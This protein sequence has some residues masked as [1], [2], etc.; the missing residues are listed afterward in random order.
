MR[1]HAVRL[2]FSD[3][4]SYAG[5]DTTVLGNYRRS[6]LFMETAADDSRE[7]NE[8]VA[9]LQGQ[10]EH[11]RLM[12]ARSDESESLVQRSDAEYGTEE[13]GFG[14]NPLSLRLAKETLRCVVA[15]YP[16]RHRHGHKSGSNYEDKI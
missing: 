5:G 16:A 3:R 1:V 10:V 15:E 11:A 13:L 14:P 2:V 9:F 4:R 8:V 6:I 7:G 12:V